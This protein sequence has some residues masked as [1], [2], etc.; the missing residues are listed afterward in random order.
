[1]THWHNSC[2]WH[3]WVIY[4]SPNAHITFNA[5]KTTAVYLQSLP[6]VSPNILEDSV[7][8]ILVGAVDGVSYGVH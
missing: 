4:A 6:Y 7:V 3:Q 2:N 1:M 8:E 5:T